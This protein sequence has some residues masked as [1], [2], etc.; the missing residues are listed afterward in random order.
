MGDVGE[1]YEIVPLHPERFPH[2]LFVKWPEGALHEWRAENEVS[3][4]SID[5]Y[6]TNPAWHG[7]LVCYGGVGATEHWKID[8][9][10]IV[11]WRK[12]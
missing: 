8:C 1:T 5:A 6:I 11:A 7:V 2:L 3:Y 9:R 4:P 10:H 12:L